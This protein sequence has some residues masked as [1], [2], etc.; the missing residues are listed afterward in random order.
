MNL[1]LDTHAILWALT[2]DPRLS[3]TARGAYENAERPVFSMV[4]LWEIGIKL[5]LNRPDF[6]LRDDWWRVIPETLTRQG[7]ARLDI[8][9]E[10]CRRV[11]G[12]PPHHRDPFDRLL[13]AQALDL[14]ADILSCDAKL[15]VFGVGRVW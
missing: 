8:E 2:E 4:S 7:V 10:H 14:D 12:L 6:R 3:D 13:A 5:G 11:A 15:D 9:P 1:L